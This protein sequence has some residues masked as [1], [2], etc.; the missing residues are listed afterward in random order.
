MSEARTKLDILY[1]DVLGDVR[2]VIDKAEAISRDIDAKVIS[3][4]SELEKQTGVMLAAV[5][6]LRKVLV[7]MTRQV[8]EY[9]T[10]ATR[11]AVENGKREIQ[12]A[13]AG[14]VRASVGGEVTQ[15]ISDVH[16]ASRELL[17]QARLSKEDLKR[18]ARQVSWSVWQRS[19]V[20][21]VS[22][23]LSAGALFLGLKASGLLASPTP[24]VLSQAEARTFANGQALE[25]IWNQLTPKEQ[26]RIN[27]LAQQGK[28]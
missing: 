19:G 23:L 22:S 24:P 25:R 17:D 18:A 1:Q 12:H 3:A 28:K 7:D 14:I 10:E 5:E 16:T 20:V 13:A 4:G 11:K 8:D 26:Q 2:E 27:Q 21:V 9:A 6:E 15:A